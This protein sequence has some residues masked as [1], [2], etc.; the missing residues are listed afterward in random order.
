MH[1]HSLDNW[2]HD[3]AF[4]DMSQQRNERLVY[5]VISSR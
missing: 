1:I 2:R 4:L 3:H 5:W